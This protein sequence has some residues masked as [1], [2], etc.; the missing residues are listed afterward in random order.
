MRA[1][2]GV[3]LG[4]VAWLMAAPYGW[5]TLMA[6]GGVSVAGGFARLSIAEAPSLPETDDIGWLAPARVEAALRGLSVTLAGFPIAVAELTELTIEL[7][8]RGGPKAC[9]MTVA[10]DLARAPAPLAALVITY[11]VDAVTHDLFRG[12]LHTIAT[13][14]DSSTGYAM[15]F[16]PKMAALQD[17]KAFR[18]VIIDSDLDNWSTEQGPQASSNVWGATGT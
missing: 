7:D 13:A 4:G 11:T 17:H 18:T 12:R 14:V 10:S 1:A 16:A 2:G 6:R 5:D 8:D 15:T 9:S 3:S